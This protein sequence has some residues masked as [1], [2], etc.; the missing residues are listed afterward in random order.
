MYTEVNETTSLDEFR[1]IYA[2]YFGDIKILYSL[3]SLSVNLNGQDYDG[4]SALHLAASEGRL[5]AV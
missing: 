3:H 1:L 2:S 4:R 5:E